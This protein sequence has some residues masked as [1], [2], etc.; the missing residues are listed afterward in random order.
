M[1]RRAPTRVPPAAAEPTSVFCRSHGAYHAQVDPTFDD[2]PPLKSPALQGARAYV[3]KP[4]KGGMRYLR[5]VSARLESLGFALDTVTNVWLRP[6]VV[7]GIERR[8]DV[9]TLRPLDS[10][11]E[12]RAEVDPGQPWGQPKAR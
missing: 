7:D 11:D 6:K 1:C 12:G 9:R 8:I 10:D 3:V 2:W 4:G 5:N